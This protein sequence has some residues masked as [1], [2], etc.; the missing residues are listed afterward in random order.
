M[1]V[2]SSIQLALALDLKCLLD[3]YRRQNRGQKQPLTQGEKIFQMIHP[4]FMKLL[5][6]LKQPSQLMSK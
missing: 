4:R 2:T 6:L 5:R 1:S 3:L